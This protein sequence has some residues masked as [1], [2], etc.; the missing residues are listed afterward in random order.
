MRST[1]IIVALMAAVGAT[2]R[3]DTA[4][5]QEK[6]QLVTDRNAY[7]TGDTVRFRAFLLDAASGREMHDFSRY[8]YVELLD[9]FGKVRGRVKVR[10]NDDAGGAFI[11]MLPLDRELPESHYTLAAYTMYMQNQGQEYFCRTPLEVRS[12]YSYKYRMEPEFANG[13]MTVSLTERSTGA[14][15]QSESLVLS[16][17]DGVITDAG[18]NKST[19]RFKLPRNTATVMVTFDNFRKFFGVPVDSTAARLEFFAEGGA[20]VPGVTNAL[21]VKATDVD[22]RP[23]QVSGEVTDGTGAGVARFR[24]DQRGLARVNFLPVEGQ[25]YRVMACGKTFDLPRPDAGASALQVVATRGSQFIVDVQGKRREGSTIVARVRGNVE[26][27]ADAARAPLSIPLESLSAG[28]VR[29]ELRGS[30]GKVL[31]ARTAYNY[32]PAAADDLSVT[33]GGSYAIASATAAVPSAEALA[34]Q[35]DLKDPIFDLTHY[36][37]HSDRT[38]RTDMDALMLT[39]TTDRYAPTDAEPAFPVEV[40]GE[41]SGI[42]KSRWRGKPMKNARINII[43]PSLGIAQDA[44]TDADGRFCINGIDWPDG[45]AFACQAINSKGNREHNFTMATDTFPSIRPLPVPV[46]TEA[47]VPANA[48]HLLRSGIQLNEIQVT[49]PRSQ[50]EMLSTMYKAMGIRTMDQDYFAEHSITSYEEVIQTIPGLRI[51][52]GRILTNRRNTLYGGVSPVEIWVDGCLW[53]PSFSLVDDLEITPFKPDRNQVVSDGGGAN[54]AM[55][56]AIGNA[57]L[58]AIGPKMDPKLARQFYSVQLSEVNELA[59]SFPFSTVKSIDYV[60]TSAALMVSNAA[61][62]GGGALMITTKSGADKPWSD[63]LFIQVIKPL[64]YQSERRADLNRTSPGSVWQPDATAPAESATATTVTGFT[65]DGVFIS[66][67]IGGK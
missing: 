65:A 14:P 52:N 37:D 67:Q 5:P 15:V 8:V 63:N 44:A 6:I 51:E 61:A 64:G 12:I 19:Y 43:A 53:Q 27:T 40:G 20:L 4:Y 54:G 23:M 32:A 18:R 60:P 49:A 47:Y 16:G 7:T 62:F 30:D 66:R 42:I 46:E 17:P 13:A 2:A 1:L 39:V 31:S 24:T 48:D 9:P 28:P 36:F 45:T 55:D 22:G 29:F 21:A 41:I 10:R 3:A 57:A 11:G 33:P 34:L 26:L 50:Q 59:G 25:R 56:Q 35:S 38:A 58:K